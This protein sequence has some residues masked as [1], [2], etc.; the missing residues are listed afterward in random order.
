VPGTYAIVKN[1]VSDADV[2]IP[3]DVE[4]RLM[5]PTATAASA[6]GITITNG[7]ISFAKGGIYEIS[8]TFYVTN[9]SVARNLT[10][11]GQFV[12][13]TSPGLAPNT[14]EVHY[15]PIAT[16]TIREVANTFILNVTDTSAGFYIGLKQASGA[17]VMY[18]V[19]A[20]AYG[21]VPVPSATLAI[22]QLL[23]AQSGPAGATGAGATGVAGAT[24][25]AGATGYGATGPEGATGPAGGPTGATGA[26]GAPGN[27]A[28]NLVFTTAASVRRLTGFRDNGT[29]DVV[30]PIRTVSLLNG[31]L[32]L[33]L[34][35]FNPTL[36]QSNITLN[37]DIPVA[38]WFIA[39]TN[40]TDTPAQF[41][42]EP[43]SLT[44]ITGVFPGLDKY[45]RTGTI[46]ASLTNMLLTYP[47]GTEKILSTSD[48]YLGGTA[49]ADVTVNYSN[50]G[51]V[52]PW[53]TVESPAKS[54]VIF[55]WRDATH[56]IAIT[57]LTGN[58]FLRAYTS[59][60]YTPSTPNISFAANRTFS[61]T[62][63]N[64]KASAPYN[65]TDA[66][67]LT[68]DTPINK[69]NAASTTTNV[70]LTT[71][72]ERPSSVI[73]NTPVTVTLGP[74]ESASVNTNAQFTYPSFYVFT[75][76]TS[77][78]PT[79]ATIVSGD[80]FAGGVQVL[81]SQAKAF[82]GL[83]TVPAGNPVAFWFGVRNAASPPTAFKTGTK[84]EDAANVA[85]VVQRSVDLGP[86]PLPTDQTKEAYRLWGFTLQPGT[87]YVSIS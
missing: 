18:L 69:T 11:Y 4:V 50:A 29:P 83:I 46:G 47:V 61:I 44:P 28:G 54:R 24:G 60:T 21:G 23:Y 75:A 20:I 36:I 32:E 17:G 84:A 25:T 58:T 33:T 63:N 70:T 22:R 37:W 66:G 10:V 77:I 55:T 19:K 65:T 12:G 6:E 53:P 35:S 30:A 2:V 52:G 71:T 40:P 57:P 68:F 87:T 15:I 3:I 31:I 82:A 1:A 49:S 62:A 27:A 42:T 67:T 45:T 43:L 76:E 86:N 8:Y 16:T 5:R 72:C 74:T 7:I 64:S 34:A 56:N 80:G 41:I 73:G 59:T 39:A 48:N 13:G 38:S 81:D 26:S 85:G 9:S 78:V 14:T 79:E 51:V